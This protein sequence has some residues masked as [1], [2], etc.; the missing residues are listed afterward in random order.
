MPAKHY[1]LVSASILNSC[2][3]Y[4]T[5]AKGMSVKV[6]DFFKWLE[7]QQEVVIQKITILTA[8]HCCNSMNS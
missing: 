3:A 7:K 8:N 1:S 4:R 6:L 5:L 2:C